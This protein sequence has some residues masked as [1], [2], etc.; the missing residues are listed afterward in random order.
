MNQHVLARLMQSFANA[1]L[2][3]KVI[4]A[5]ALHYA[6]HGDETIIQDAAK[7]WAEAVKLE[8]ELQHIVDLYRRGLADYTSI[9]EKRTSIAKFVMKVLG[10]ALA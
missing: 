3:D 1:S 5:G 4:I 7:A 6:K 8:I 2:A 10:E 9:L